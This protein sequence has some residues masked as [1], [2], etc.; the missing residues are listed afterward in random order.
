MRK[1]HP[2]LHAEA[3]AA[4]RG[5][6]SKLVSVFDVHGVRCFV[7]S[8]HT[9]LLGYELKELLGHNYSETVLPLDVTHAQLATA[10]AELTGE[11][12]PVTAMM[13]R[14]SGE[15]ITVKGVGRRIIDPLTGEQFFLSISTVIGA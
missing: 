10:D 13:R 3:E 1:L 5:N 2:L 9:K 11:T 8:A 6:P 12:T 15:I 14:K 7:S 4:E